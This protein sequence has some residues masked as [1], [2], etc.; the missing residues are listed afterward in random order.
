VLGLARTNPSIVIWAQSQNAANDSPNN[1]IEHAWS[2]IC[3]LLSGLVIPSTAEG[4]HVEPKKLT[5]ISEDERLEKTKEVLAT[6]MRM[7]TE[8]VTSEPIRGIGARLETVQPGSKRDLELGARYQLLMKFTH[9]TLKTMKG[10]FSLSVSL[11]LSL[12]LDIFLFF[13]SSLL[14]FFSFSLFSFSLSRVSSISCSCFC[15]ASLGTDDGVA[16][17]TCFDVRAR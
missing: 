11:C 7:V 1:A 3:K 9:A 13:S 17:Q 15:A 6:G 2:P 12:S 10:L 8:R 16:P 14:L 4:D 5:G